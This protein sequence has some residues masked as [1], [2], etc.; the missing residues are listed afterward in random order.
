MALVGI[1]FPQTE[2]FISICSLKYLKPSPQIK[3]PEL[4]I[5]FALHKKVKTAG[6]RPAPRR[7]NQFPRAPF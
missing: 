6:R 4:N 2:H 1:I 7:G 5:M 3:Q